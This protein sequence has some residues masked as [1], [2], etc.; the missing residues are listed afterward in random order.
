MSKLNKKIPSALI[1]LCVIITSAVAQSG[2]VRG[3]APTTGKAGDQDA[4][5]L[6]VEEVLLPV[7]V[8]SDTGKLPTHLNRQDFV[9]V[10]DEKR[11]QVTS[12]IR[13]PANILLILDAGGAAGS[14]KNIQIHRDLAR[15]IL[16]SLGDEDKAAIIA[17]ADKVTV[18]SSWTGD[19]KALR[20]SLDW[21]FKPGLKS[22]LY[23]S[24]LHA[25]EELLPKVEGRRSVVI[26][27]DGVDSS[28]PAAFNKALAALH[29]T[30]A[31]VYALSQGNMIQRRLKPIIY[32][33]LAWYEML[34]PKVSKRYRGLRNYYQ[35][36]ESG[37]AMLR[38][39]AEETGGAMW[40]PEARI[41]CADG[42]KQSSQEWQLKP[43]TDERAIDCE[44]LRKQIIEEIGTEYVVAYLSERRPDDREFHPIK[45]FATRNDI[46][47]RAR[48]GVYASQ[49]AASKP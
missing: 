49:P 7:S 35:Q 16:E 36:I 24:L 4:I 28:N 21:K 3:A 40:D 32:N 15:Q 27:T 30:R 6:R 9:V 17:Y 2:R 20:E 23:E 42:G 19:K 44:T 34:D 14:Y 8:R 46:K 29:H 39:L 1:I 18:L 11:Q 43:A 38:Q 47:V 13:T 5:R 37:R 45:V 26:L 12:V 33:P 41:E 25:A 48:R 22:G 31:T 10:E